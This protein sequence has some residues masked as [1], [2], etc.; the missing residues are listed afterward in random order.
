MAST[1]A[2]TTLS[3]CG[4]GIQFASVLCLLGG[5]ASIAGWV[6]TEEPTEVLNHQI[7][8]VVAVP[9]MGLLASLGA[10]GIAAGSKIKRGSVRAS[11]WFLGVVWFIFLGTACHFVATTTNLYEVLFFAFLV[12][13]GHAA[14]AVQRQVARVGK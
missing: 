13:D 11:K 14:L 10:L 12:I 5:L 9:L 2:E 3:V 7:H 4:T 1:R 6:T 8:A